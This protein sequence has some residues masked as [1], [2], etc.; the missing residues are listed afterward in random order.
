MHM[1]VQSHFLHF[2]LFGFFGN[3][4]FIMSSICFLT[5][6][7]TFSSSFWLMSTSD[8]FPWSRW[9]TVAF[10]GFRPS[11]FREAI[12]YSFNCFL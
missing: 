12:A 8:V 7:S 1:C 11:A 2:S 4:L 5:S 3:F 9:C 6:F 10:L